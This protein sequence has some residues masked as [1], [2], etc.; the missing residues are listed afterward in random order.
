MSC[1]TSSASMSQGARGKENPA[2]RQDC[3]FLMDRTHLDYVYALDLVNYCLQI[4]EN[5]IIQQMRE[6]CLKRSSTRTS[7][8]LGGI[9]YLIY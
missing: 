3:L 8:S 5:G 1:E 7:D 4:D 6:I 9:T 2:G